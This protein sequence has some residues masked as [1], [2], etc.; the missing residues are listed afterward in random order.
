MKKLW[1]IPAV[2]AG[3]AAARTIAAGKKTS[4]WKPEKTNPALSEKLSKM[5]QAETVSEPGIYDKAKF[6]R[7]HEVLEE[8]FPRTFSTLEV[9]NIDGNLLLYWKGKSH[10]RPIVIMSHQDVVPAEGEWKHPP[11]SGDI[12]EGKV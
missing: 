1:L 2:I 5:V 10:D 7:F 9:N 6:D 8:L 11:F 4:T 3:V 12:A